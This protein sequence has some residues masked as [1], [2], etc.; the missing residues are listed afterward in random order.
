LLRDES[1]LQS[2][3]PPPIVARGVKD[4]V[5]VK[6]FADDR[7]KD[8]VRKTVCEHASNLSIAMNNAKQLRIIL[9]AVCRSQYLVD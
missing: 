4:R 1:R 9:R 8:S 6:R 2:F 5:N 7:E 3:R